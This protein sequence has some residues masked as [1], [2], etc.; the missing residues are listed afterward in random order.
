MGTEKLETALD[1]VEIKQTRNKVDL[2]RFRNEAINKVKKENYV[3]GKKALQVYSI[4]CFKR[5][6][7]K[8]IK[9]SCL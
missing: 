9:A 3:F 2:I 6:S 1:K 5:Y 7:S 8:R 4:N